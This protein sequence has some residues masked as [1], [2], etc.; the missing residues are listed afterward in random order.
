MRRRD[1]GKSLSLVCILCCHIPIDTTIFSFDVN[2]KSAYF[3]YEHVLNL[4][5]LLASGM[6][7]VQLWSVAFLLRIWSHAMFGVP[8]PCPLDL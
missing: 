5:A 2:Y 3:K 6:Y 8:E 4:D 7:Y 1:G